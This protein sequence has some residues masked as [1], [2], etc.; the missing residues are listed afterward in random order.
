M[1]SKNTI[2]A[3]PNI[4]HISQKHTI[5]SQNIHSISPKTTTTTKQGDNKNSISQ[6]TQNRVNPGTNWSQSSFVFARHSVHRASSGFFLHSDSERPF[7][8]V[9][10][11][12]EAFFFCTATVRGLLSLAP[13]TALPF[14]RLS[15]LSQDERSVYSRHVRGSWWQFNLLADWTTALARQTYIAFPVLT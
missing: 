7:F 11:Q 13:P 10:R 3:R 2:S 8:S 12:R 9:Q 15:E 1:S 5:F 14:S 4:Y 6:S